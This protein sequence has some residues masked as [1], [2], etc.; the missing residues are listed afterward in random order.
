MCFPK[1]KAETILV[2]LLLA[3]SSSIGF[4]LV[5][6]RVCDYNGIIIMTTMVNPVC[7]GKK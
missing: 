1:W 5:D 3:A 2:R 7:L 6:V 4:F